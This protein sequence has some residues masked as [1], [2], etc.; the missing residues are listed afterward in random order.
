[1]IRTGL[2]WLLTLPVVKDNLLG[3]HISPYGDHLFAAADYYTW[4]VYAPT[5]SLYF[6]GSYLNSNA[7]RHLIGAIR[8]QEVLHWSNPHLGRGGVFVTCLTLR[9]P[10]NSIFV[11]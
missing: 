11:D 3:R 9:R 4:F 6:D 7:F 8:E 5:I 10:R 2:T 1:M